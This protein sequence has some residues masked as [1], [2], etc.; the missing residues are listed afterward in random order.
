MLA[1]SFSALAS[2]LMIS[3]V[4][5]VLAL[6]SLSLH[7]Q[8]LT[9]RWSNLVADTI[10]SNIEGMIVKTGPDSHVV[11]VY[12]A[13]T[14][15]RYNDILL[16]KSNASTSAKIWQANSNSPVN[17]GDFALDATI[18]GAGNVIVV[19]GRNDSLLRSSFYAANYSGTNGSL[20]WERTFP[21]GYS[22]M[23]SR[24]LSQPP[25]INATL[26]TSL[27]LTACWSSMK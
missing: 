1:R 12:N 22:D 13:F 7:A 3:A 20:M 21:S 16:I 27:G 23:Q 11:T 9:Q 19:G 4:P 15:S 2:R 17:F 5:G 14:S 8:P 18:D 26:P 6:T 24:R 10:W 25:C